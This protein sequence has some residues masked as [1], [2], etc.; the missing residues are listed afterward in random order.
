MNSSHKGDHKE[1]STIHTRTETEKKKDE[2][3]KKHD[4]TTSPRRAFFSAHKKKFVIGLVLF[5]V[6]FGLVTREVYKRPVSD[7]F[8]RAVASVVPYP[9]LTLNGT[10]VSIKEY[11][12]EYDALV[13]FF[14]TDD[15]S[16]SD[17]ELEDAISETLVNKIAVRQLAKQYDV[18]IDKQEA[19]DYYQG[20]LSGQ[21]SEDVFAQELSDTFGWTI[22]EFKENIVESIVLALQ[23]NTFVLESDEIQQDRMEAMDVALERV[24]SGEEFAQVAKDVHGVYDDSLESDLG[25]I[26]ASAIPSAWVDA[27]ENLEIGEFTE[28][29]ELEEGF[30]IFFVNDS[31]VAGEDTQLHL[32]AITVQKQTLEKV[33][34]EFLEGSELKNYID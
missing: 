30:A 13:S 9:A 2:T 28:V 16:P 21:E 12:N 34:E 29:L 4:V 5:L 11:L 20:I 3:H 18:E 10:T 6:V 17:H 14:S 33:V 15:A 19:E 1:H 26:K 7:G 24:R 31:I 32:F 25:Y 8:V 23:M 22:N 27:V